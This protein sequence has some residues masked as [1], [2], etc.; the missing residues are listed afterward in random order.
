MDSLFGVSTTGLARVLVA[1]SALVLLGLGLIGLRRRTLMRL[2]LRN[3]ARRPLR[4]VVIVVGLMLSTVVIATAFSTGDAMTLTV[5]SLITG[6]IG[7]VDEIVTASPTDP[8]QVSRRSL[9]NL[10][11][12][13]GLMQGSTP[14]FD[15]RELAT[16]SAAAGNSHA[17]AGVMP[18]ILEQAPVAAGGSQLIHPGIGLLALPPQMAAGF[19]PLRDTAGAARAIAALGATDV[20]L[21]QAAADTLS[22]AAGQQI[23][24]YLA[25]PGARPGTQP[26][27]TTLNVVAV[28][29][30]GDLAGAQPTVFLSIPAMQ[31]LRGEPGQINQILVINRCSASAACSHQAALDLRKTLVNR[32]AAEQIVQALDSSNGRSVLNGLIARRN[33][34]GQAQ[35]RDLLHT[36]A[37]GKVSDHLIYL[38]GDPQ[39]AGTLRATA[40]FLPTREGRAGRLLRNLNA[41]TVVEVKQSALDQAN[42][43]GS[44]L[45]SSFLVLGLFSIAASL[46][47]VFLVF[48]MLAAE[49]R[50]EMGMARA[51]GLQR[52]HLIQSFAFEGML[53]DLASALLGVGVGV[54]VAAGVVRL[55]AHALSSYGIGVQNTV[56]PRSLV[57]AFCLGLLVTFATVLVS[58]W[59]VSRVNIVEAIRGVPAEAGL[60]H[61]MASEARTRLRALSRGLRS[62]GAGSGRRAAGLLYSGAQAL[63]TL[64]AML[65][66][67]GVLPAVIGVYMLLHG[68]VRHQYVIFALG[69]SLVLLGGALLLRWLLLLLRF[70]HGPVERGAYTLAGA[71]LTAF[72]SFPPPFWIQRHDHLAVSRIETFALSGVMMV[73][74]V[75]VVLAYNLA[76]PLQ[77]AAGLVRRGGAAA[78]AVKMAVAYPLQHRFRTGMAVAMFSLVVFTMVVS[79]V[80][81]E[82]AHQAYVQRERPPVGYDI[83]ATAPETARLTDIN[84]ALAGAPATQTDQFS[85]IGSDATVSME[86]VQ[87]TGKAASWHTATIRLA[88]DGMLRG[89]RL[90]LSTRASGYSSDTAVWDALATRPGM[91]VVAISSLPDGTGYSAVGLSAPKPG[92]SG[93]RPEPIWLRD[94]SGAPVR[95]TVIGVVDDH[96][97]LP[98][99]LLTRR[100]NITTPTAEA[101]VPTAFYFQTRPGRDPSQAALGLDLSFALQGL[102]TS[103]VG[104]GLRNLQTVRGLLNYLLEGFVG[105]G[106][107]SGMAALGVI[108]TRAVVE[109]RQE[110]GMLRAIGLRR[111]WVQ[112]SFLMEVSLIA[113]LGVG[114]G[115]G[116]GVLLARNVVVFLSSDFRELSL[117]VPWGEVGL[118]AL[119]AYLSALS[120][121]LFAAWQAGRIDPAE[122]LRYE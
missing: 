42:Q 35:I 27:A 22:S 14:Y 101:A 74:G 4:S 51:V 83:S 117:H 28:V 84:A 40:S 104:E 122:A 93:F 15:E 12:G 66:S 13:G 60:D 75:V 20:Y 82:S 68:R 97:A 100:S 7:R 10:A 61:G 23:Q 38:L 58:A 1:L 52:S 88:D 24:V 79:A 8:T 34:P 32:D 62:L 26:V 87:P 76:G 56:S 70:P 86:L 31:Q 73:A 36:V 102:Q 16:V 59:R 89:T 108:S 37:Q 57:I 64:P 92:E 65:T 119:I 85:A 50:G 116:L 41:L 112:A 44:I 91:A 43:Y 107:V 25:P 111:R 11:S 90:R 29:K 5:R 19:S 105:L 18:A 55:V 80:L 99:G 49:R 67:R 113:L 33:G 2:G 118:I 106:L 53:Y 114:V 71:A 47:L 30:N 72:W 94:S 110:I 46:L 120:T 48:V 63:L 69:V 6:S 121:T 45:T 78:A 98:S 96:D 103:V 109:R 21:N 3:A 77:A 115:V 39:V 9:D 54:I 95:L 81:L 17:I